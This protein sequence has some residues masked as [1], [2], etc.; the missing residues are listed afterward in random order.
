[1]DPV[2]PWMGVLPMMTRK[3]ALINQVFFLSEQLGLLCHVDEEDIQQK[4]KI[5]LGLCG[6][7]IHI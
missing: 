3:P 4:I 2:D 6:A 1:M 5:H 7:S